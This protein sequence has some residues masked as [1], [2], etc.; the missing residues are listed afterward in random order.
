MSRNPAQ[1]DRARQLRRDMTPAE[2][3]LWEHLR[4]RRFA[5]FKFRRQQPI[6][7]FYVDVVCRECRLIV[8]VDGETHLGQETKD[9]KRTEH[10]NE[11][12][13][14][15]LR[16]WNNQVYDEIEAVLEAIYRACQERVPQDSQPS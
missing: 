10:L 11:R 2:G 1:R 4:G 5:G 13:W 15:V 8:E 3:V 16:F 14:L 12:K 9:E 6:G 7:P